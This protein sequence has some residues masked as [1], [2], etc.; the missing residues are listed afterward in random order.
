MKFIKALLLCLLSYNVFAGTG[1]KDSPFTVSQAIA[2]TDGSAQT[3][4]VKGYIV[5]E[6]SDFSNNKYFYELAPPF[7]GTSAYLIADNP[8][9]I[10]LKKC[11]LEK[12]TQLISFVKLNKKKKLIILEI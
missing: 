12:K 1:S 2:K 10:D 3:Y 4:W 8:N 5:G 11:M 9:E 7:D 6:M